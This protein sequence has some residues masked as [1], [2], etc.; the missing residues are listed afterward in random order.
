MKLINKI[1]IAN[2]GEI[3]L[4]IASTARKMGISTVAL[5][6]DDDLQASHIKACDEAVKLN[7]DLLTET[8]LN[9]E[10]IINAATLVNADAIHPGYGFLSENTLF[11]KACQ[12]ANIIFIGPD[13]AVI[14]LMGDK[15]AARNFVQSIGLPVAA[16]F[17]IDIE[18]FT[19]PADATFP[20][21]LK[22]VA[23]GGGK[24]MYVVHTREEF[25]E[26]CKSASAE[27][28]R[29]FGDGRLYAER[30]IKEARHIEVQLLADNL[31]NVIHLFERECSVQRR[32]QK[33]IEEAPSAMIE[34]EVVEGIRNVAVEIAKRA[35]YTNA[36][37]IEFLL[38]P[39][40]AFFFMEMNTRIQ[41]E[42]PVTEMI[43]GI[44]LIEQQIRVASGENLRYT[45]DE[46]RFEGHAVEARL[47]AE[48]P[49]NDFKPEAGD[50]VYWS[51]PSSEGIR[52][53]SAIKQGTEITPGYDPML[54]KVIAHGITREEAY[55]KLKYTLKRTALHGFNTNLPLLRHL[56]SAIPINNRP[57]DT[58]WLE[59]NIE[60]IKSQINPANQS[61][62]LMSAFAWLWFQ[63]RNNELYQP[64]DARRY[65]GTM[66][67]SA[68]NV[69]VEI[70]HQIKELSVLS[71]DSSS[72]SVSCAEEIFEISLL[73]KTD[74]RL[75][76]LS[77]N[78]PLTFEYSYMGK[79]QIQVGLAGETTTIVK[80]H[81]P[82]SGVVVNPSLNGHKKQTRLTSSLYGRVI[83]IEAH[84]GQMVN[85]GDLLLVIESM[86]M[87]NR[88]L[89]LNES[90][91]EHIKVKRGDHIKTGMD[92]VTFR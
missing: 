43:T 66:V 28:I 21:L 90:V 82:E 36:G 84:E 27:A 87:E 18:T 44:D 19:L 25:E 88:I 16:G 24:A 56:T 29:Y 15:S 55:R 76:L 2:R 62:A 83:H 60:S 86:K 50:L 85:K 80:R 91:I 40:G 23:G 74:H 71:Y 38:D 1:L 69:Q 46:I 48:D 70:D 81:I 12:E 68:R 4:R 47:Y 6:T 11:A 41:V 30:F 3:A 10:A 61:S 67:T 53:D 78:Q 37:T 63:E 7:G 9:I 77:N 17:N 34:R 72:M 59:R 42:H 35:N 75:Q 51:V 58:R 45:Q 5:Y 89:A 33:V 26:K 79:D 13:P 39:S 32:Q 8:W 57:P 92:L 54:A 64:S 52:V 31:G 73:S 49:L 20:L 65:W 22:P 14:S